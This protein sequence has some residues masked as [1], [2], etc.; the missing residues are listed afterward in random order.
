MVSQVEVVLSSHL[1][2]VV[3]IIAFIILRR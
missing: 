1:N 2:R 3:T